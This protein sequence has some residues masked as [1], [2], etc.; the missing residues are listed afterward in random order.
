[1][2][3]HARASESSASD[4]SGQSGLLRLLG[5]LG[6]ESSDAYRAPCP[7]QVF[8]SR[9]LKTSEEP[10]NLTGSHRSSSTPV[11]AAMLS[12]VFEVINEDHTRYTLTY[13]YTY[14]GDA[15]GINP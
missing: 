4:R 5:R 3:W 14:D 2:A 6:S 9:R 12:G 15:D 8:L 7:A 13:M 11:N 1:M 10:Q